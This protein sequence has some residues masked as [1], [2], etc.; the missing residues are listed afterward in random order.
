MLMDFQKI[1]FPVSQ[2]QWHK[3]VYLLSLL[4]W[5][6]EGVVLREPS[7]IEQSPIGY[8]TL[9][10]PKTLS[11]VLYILNS[12]QNGNLKS[13]GFVQSIWNWLLAHLVTRVFTFTVF[14]V[15]MDFKIY[16]HPRE[17]FKKILATFHIALICF[18]PRDPFAVSLL[19]LGNEN[20]ICAIFK[21]P[22]TYALFL[23]LYLNI[24]FYILKVCILVFKKLHLLL[25]NFHSDSRAFVRTGAADE[26]WQNIKPLVFYR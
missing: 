17:A 15:S 23:L 14:L 19:V 2:Y 9:S 12:H 22:I 16:F 10:I 13:P 6:I 4:L 24:A 8:S 3:E 7:F 21:T 1:I 11:C 5:V 25:P 26:C 20:P 18:L